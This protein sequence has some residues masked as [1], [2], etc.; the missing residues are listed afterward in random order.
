MNIGHYLRSMRI[1]Y[2]WVI[3]GFPIEIKH[4]V[5]LNLIILEQDNTINCEKR[6]LRFKYYILREHY[7]AVDQN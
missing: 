4:L 3:L 7:M 1:P 2:F 5:V 6:L